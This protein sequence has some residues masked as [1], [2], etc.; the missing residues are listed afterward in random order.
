MHSKNKEGVEWC[1][2]LDKNAQ[3]F[4]TNTCRLNTNIW[5]LQFNFFQKQQKCKINKNPWNNSI[6][7]LS[8]QSTFFL[9]IKYV[10]IKFCIIFLIISNPS[11]KQNY[12]KLVQSEQMLGKVI[13]C[14]DRNCANNRRMLKVPIEW[15][16]S[17][18]SVVHIL[19]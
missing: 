1:S 5:S 10:F 11:S 13:R 3:N 9:Q 7:V 19:V 12:S 17:F 15:K 4:L 14:L 16:Y 6:E 18:H 2:S 8:Q